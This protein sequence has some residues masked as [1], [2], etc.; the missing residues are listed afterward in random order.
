MNRHAY[1][2]HEKISK[3]LK[4]SKDDENCTKQFEPHLLF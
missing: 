4:H 2:L 1:Q 3:T